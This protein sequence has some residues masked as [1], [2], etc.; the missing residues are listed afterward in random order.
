MSV[1]S[2]V[3]RNLRPD[4]IRRIETLPEEDL[5]LVNEVLLHAE[6]ERLWHEISAEAENEKQNGGWENLPEIIEQAR[7]R[8]R[9]A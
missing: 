5:V 4:L 3:P 2:P 9:S 7:A 8:L 6:K 1:S